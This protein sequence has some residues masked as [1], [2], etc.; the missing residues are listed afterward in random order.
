MSE[1]DTGRSGAARPPVPRDPPDQQATGEEDPLEIVVPDSQKRSDGQKG[2]DGQQKSDG[3]EAEEDEGLPDT[4]E[5]GSGPKGR[6]PKG[7]VHPE[8]PTPQEP[9]D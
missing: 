6:A 7:T 5:A 4:D 8:H 9:A 2:P 3:H 1:R